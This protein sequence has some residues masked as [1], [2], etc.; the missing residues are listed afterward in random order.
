MGA[1]DA[2]AQ[3]KAKTFKIEVDLGDGSGK[4]TYTLDASAVT[5]APII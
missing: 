4:I 2:A 3:E 1:T 5:Y